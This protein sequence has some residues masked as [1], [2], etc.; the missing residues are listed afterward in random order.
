[1]TPT[2]THL[3][4]TQVQRFV[5]PTCFYETPPFPGILHTSIQKWLMQSFP[6]TQANG[7]ALLNTN[8]RS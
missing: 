4:Y 3:M 1:M 8:N 6:L 5:T 7:L 2:N